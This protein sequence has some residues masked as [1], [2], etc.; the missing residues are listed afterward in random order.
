MVTQRLHL[1]T[2]SSQDVA[3]DINYRVRDLANGIVFQ[4]LSIDTTWYCEYSQYGNCAVFD[5]A[6]PVWYI[7]LATICEMACHDP[8]FAEKLGIDLAASTCPRADVEEFIADNAGKC[9]KHYIAARMNM[10]CMFISRDLYRN[11]HAEFK[12]T[13][14]RLCDL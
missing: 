11:R 12:E 10:Y 13:I 5:K 9:R 14:E 1:R 7:H 2:E 3:F 4:K 6:A 8:D